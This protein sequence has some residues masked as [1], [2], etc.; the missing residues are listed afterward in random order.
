MTS[1]EIDAA[2]AEMFA[3]LDRIADRLRELVRVLDSCADMF[4]NTTSADNSAAEERG[5]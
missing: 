3:K 4:D 1:A 5:R 2:Y